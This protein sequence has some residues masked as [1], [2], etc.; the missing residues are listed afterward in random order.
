MFNLLVIEIVT[1]Y[2][3]LPIICE[4]YHL[5]QCTYKQTNMYHFT[6][7]VTNYHLMQCTDM[8]FYAMYIAYHFMKCTLPLCT[9]GP[10]EWLHIPF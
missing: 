10:A 6:Q 1:N 3:H 9:K 2:Y 5:V 8:P 7:I 4:T